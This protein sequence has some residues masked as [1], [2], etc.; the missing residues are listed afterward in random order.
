MSKEVSVVLV[1]RDRP[2]LAAKAIASILACEG[3]VYE[4]VVVDQGETPVDFPACPRVRFV[5]SA[6]G[7]SRGRNVGVAECRYELIGCT[8]DD[9][10]VSQDWVEQVS[11]A[12]QDPTIGMVFGNVSPGQGYGDAIPAHINQQARTASSVWQRNRI[13]GMGACMALRRS[14]WSDTGGFDECLGAGAHMQSGEETDFAI[15]VLQRGFRVGIEPRLEVVHL[16]ARSRA[17]AVQLTASYW[18][19]TGAAFAKFLRSSPAAAS[20]SLAG[21]GLRW[22]HGGGSQVTKTTGAR[23]WTM[24]QAFLWGLVWGLRTPMHSGCFVIGPDDDAISSTPARR[25]SPQRKQGKTGGL[26]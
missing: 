16:G 11:L 3:V 6:P 4:V 25:P 23:R 26:T 21:L 7:L 10:L 5:R 1:T 12:L 20:Y 2:A 24:L 8:D 18:G 9:C 15:R 19:G 13:E 22:L 14:V 17:E